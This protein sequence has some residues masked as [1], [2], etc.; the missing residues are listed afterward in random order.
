[1]VDNTQIIDSGRRVI[2]H[3]AR[4]LDIMAGIIDEVFAD[5]VNLLLKTKGRIVVT[6]VGKS[7]HI[8]RKIAATL[9]STGTPALFVHASEANHGDMGMIAEGDVVVMLSNSGGST[10]LFSIAE[11][12]KYRSIPIA[13]IVGKRP[14]HIAD[15]ADYVLLLPEISE[16]TPLSVPTASSTMMLAIGDALAICVMQ[17]RGF[18]KENHKLLHPAGVIGISLKKVSELMHAGS[19]IPL[20]DV[21]TK[22]DEAIIEMTRKRFGCT[23]VLKNGCLVGIIT[24]GDLRRHMEPSILSTRAAQVMTHN[25]VIITSDKFASEALAIMEERSITALFIVEEKNVV[26]IVHIHDLLKLGM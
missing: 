14:S 7:G 26:G 18:N 6:A 23:G 20:V 15:I 9:A 22:M 16:V 10:E 11:Y 24:D 3:E 13:A 17:I 25:P 8:A 4:A 21:D 5:V 19:A 2:A 12:C 1:M